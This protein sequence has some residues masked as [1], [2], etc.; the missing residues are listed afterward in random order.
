MSV[1]VPV[2]H[3]DMRI[4]SLLGCLL[5]SLAALAFIE[6]VA[7]AAACHVSVRQQWR[8]QHQSSVRVSHRKSPGVLGDVPELP[9]LSV[10]R[11]VPASDHPDFLPPLPT[12]VFV[13]PRV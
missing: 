5:L 11:P 4:R 12:P 10:F 7:D 6:G 9:V 13:P 8:S 1:T 3:K 2:G